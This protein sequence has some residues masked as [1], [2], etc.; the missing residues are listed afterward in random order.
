MYRRGQWGLLGGSSLNPENPTK[1]RPS[2]LANLAKSSR[3]AF[4]KRSPRK[5]IKLDSVS[6]LATLSSRGQ[7]SLDVALA[8]SPPS[9]VESVALE[10]IESSAP[11]TL[12]ETT[13][14]VTTGPSVDHLLTPPSFLADS[15]FQVWVKPKDVADPLM[16]IYADIYFLTVSNASQLQTAFSA[17]SPD[18][19]VLKAQQQSKSSSRVIRN[20]DRRTYDSAR[21]AQAA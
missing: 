12:K 4:E 19:I 18:D 11:E 15:L 10:K 21:R 20:N 6:R 1:T 8:P 7:K 5:D 2:K 16:R 17:P 9:E 3:G 14:K 13:V